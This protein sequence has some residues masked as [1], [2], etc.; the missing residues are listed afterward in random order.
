VKCAVV[1][2]V[3]VVT[4]EANASY[5]FFANSE[6]GSQCPQFWVLHPS[7]A[8]TFRHLCSVQ[9]VHCKL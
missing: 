7:F 8:L 6:K 9:E 3:S 4:M 5:S 1:S 2:I